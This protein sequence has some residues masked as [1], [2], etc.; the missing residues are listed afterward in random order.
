MTNERK[1]E[2]FDGAMNWVWEHM[3][4]FDK[5]EVEMVLEYIGFTE[6]EIAEELAGSIY[7]EDEEE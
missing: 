2:L 6:E 5:E 4:Y 3:Q 1:A 7:A